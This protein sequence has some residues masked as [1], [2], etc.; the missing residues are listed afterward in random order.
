M[1]YVPRPGEAGPP[2]GLVTA[3]GAT[4]RLQDLLLAEMRAGR[5]GFEIYRAAMERAGAEGLKA[6][7]YSHSIGHFGHFV[8]ASI[9]AFKPGARP[10]LRA[11]LP[12][13]PG[14]Y[15][16]I[17]LNTRSAVPEWGGQEVW[18]MLEDDAWLS[19]EGMRFFRPRQE[20]WIVV[21]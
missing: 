15:T 3:L 7:I 19:P 12:L 11:S 18:V 21:R 20:R 9:G 4:H 10:A 13:R 2:P 17:E 1:A 5:P 16:S 6:M 14:S 8:G